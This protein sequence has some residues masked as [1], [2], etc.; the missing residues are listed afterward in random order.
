MFDIRLGQ[1][2]KIDSVRMVF[3]RDS[4]SNVIVQELIRVIRSIPHWNVY[5]KREVYN[6]F[7]ISWTIPIYLD[8]ETRKKY[9]R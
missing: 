3:N 9:A 8:E 2:T 5:Y 6:P 7:R 1:T 4:V